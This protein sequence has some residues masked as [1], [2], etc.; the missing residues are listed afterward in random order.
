[1]PGH[2]WHI[3][4]RCHEQQ[5]LLR[6]VRDRGSWLYWLYRARRR[7]GLCV[8]NYAVTRNHVHLLVQDQGKNEI[9]AGMQLVA[10]CTAQQY[11]SRKARKGAFWEDRYHATA[12][13]TD[14]HLARCMVYIDLNMVRAG[15]V[16]HP[17]EW[18]HC[19]Y[20]EIQSP[21]QR[22]RII[23][24]DRLALLLKLDDAGQLRRV[25]RQW[26]TDKLAEG[27]TG[28]EP[29]WSD[30]IAVGNREFLEAFRQDLWPRMPGSKLRPCND[31]YRLREHV[32]AYRA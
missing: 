9:A 2:V 7:Y 32:A 15:V 12:V 27:A 24:A 23:D 4:H 16:R 3:T 19:G 8:L 11:N 29:E 25:S 17:S 20:N 6:Y 28:R 31:G 5:F 13:Q 21:P 22:Y 10:G 18:R 1:L 26:V 14:G 30:S